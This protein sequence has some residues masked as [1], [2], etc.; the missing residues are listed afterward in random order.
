MHAFDVSMFAFARRRG[1]KV[2]QTRRIHRHELRVGRCY[3]IRDRW[4]DKP[5][6]HILITRKFKQRLGDISLAD[7]QK[8][9][10][11]NLEEFKQIWAEIT[12]SW[13]PE[14]IVTAYEFQRVI[15]TPHLQVYPKTG[16]PSSAEASQQY[17]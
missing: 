8:E 15:V 1:V 4:F 6:G 9:G 3:A 17:G 7:V 2:T 11:S 13:S 14:Q 10:Y 16:K 12:G 5:K